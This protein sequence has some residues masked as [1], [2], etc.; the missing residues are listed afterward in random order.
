MVLRARLGL[1]PDEAI[2]PD[3]PLTVRG[4]PLGFEAR[5]L[6]QEFLANPPAPPSLT[7]VEAANISARYV[8]LIHEGGETEIFA[9]PTDDVPLPTAAEL[10][11]VQA[12]CA[13]DDHQLERVFS[14]GVV[15]VLNGVPDGM[16]IASLLAVSATIPS[17]ETTKFGKITAAMI[18]SE[19][20]PVRSEKFEEIFKSSLTSNPRKFRFLELYRVLENQYIRS[21]K[22]TLDDGYGAGPKA[23]LVQALASIQSELKQLTLISARHKPQFESFFDLLQTFD[24]SNRLTTA[25]FKKVNKEKITDKHAKGAAL[26]YFLRCAIV[27][28]GTKDIIFESYAD[29]ETLLSSIIEDVEVLVCGCNGIEIQE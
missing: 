4:R 22:R 27:H 8:S 10:C 26:I 19:S 29:G 25:L 23:A 11:L 1:A 15:A 12:L 3:V 28:A 5:S 20:L 24:G 2:D 7:L 16:M 17:G 21:I 9:I 18:N 6:L 13:A 14:G